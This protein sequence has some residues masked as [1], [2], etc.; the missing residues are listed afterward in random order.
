MTVRFFMLDCETD[1]PIPGDYSM[2]S[3]A[4]VVIGAPIDEMPVF[5]AELRPISDRF[6][7]EALDATGIDR[8]HFVRHGR[9][10]EKV[11]REFAAWVAWCC[12]DG[13]KPRLAARPMKFDG[14][15]QRWYSV[16]FTGE[17]PLGFNGFDL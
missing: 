5:R 8:E 7:Q 17:D 10:P 1:G 2:L 13:S 11:M 4:A 14:M 6:E 9:D 3:F 16:H 15:F 12:S